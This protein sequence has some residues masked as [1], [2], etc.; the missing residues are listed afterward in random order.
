MTAGTKDTTV[1]NST[2]CTKYEDVHAYARCRHC[3]GNFVSTHNCS[4]LTSAWSAR[5]DS[6]LQRSPAHSAAATKSLHTSHRTPLAEQTYWPAGAPRLHGFTT[7]AQGSLLFPYWAQQN[8]FPIPSLEGP[9]QSTRG[10]LHTKDPALTC[11]YT[12]R[13]QTADTIKI[14]RRCPPA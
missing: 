9:A 7:P 13:G 14:S 11:I 3:S 12:K 8:N 4:P 10:P 1:Y 5:S 6:Q 2:A